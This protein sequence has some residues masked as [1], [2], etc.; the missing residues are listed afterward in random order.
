M[1]LIA[2]WKRIFIGLIALTT[3]YILLILIR[4]ENLENK[5]EKK[6]YVY[7]NNPENFSLKWRETNFNFINSSGNL[8]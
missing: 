2:I 6:R 7:T 4:D 1:K 3:L 8:F 5:E